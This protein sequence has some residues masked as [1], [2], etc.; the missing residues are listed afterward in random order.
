[1]TGSLY[2]EERSLLCFP[3]LALLTQKMK[4]V[5]KEKKRE[6]QKKHKKNVKREEHLKLC[7]KCHSFATSFFWDLLCLHLL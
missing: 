4:M 7:S 3:Y 2:N 6:C 1:M 5:H